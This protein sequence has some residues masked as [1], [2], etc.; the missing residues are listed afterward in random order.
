MR[1][2]LC[3]SLLIAFGLGVM[4]SVGLCQGGF[5]IDT[6][7]INGDEIA[8]VRGEL[9]VK[10]SAPSV[11]H[12][13]ALEMGATV[14]DSLPRIGWWRFRFPEGADVIPSWQSLQHD[15]RLLHC[16]LNTAW[17]MPVE[18]N[19]TE[20]PAEASRDDEIQWP[21]TITRAVDAW[22]QAPPVSNVLIAI[23]DTGCDID[24]PK[25][26]GCSRIQYGFDWKHWPQFVPPED[27][28]GH[29]THRVGEIAA[30][31]NGTLCAGI[32]Q[33]CRVR[34]DKI[35]DDHPTYP[36]WLLWAAAQA[37]EWVVF[38]EGA[39]VVSCSFYGAYSSQE[40]FYP[41]RDMLYAINE[42]ARGTVVMCCAGNDG[43]QYP[44]R[45]PAAWSCDLE[46]LMCVGSSTPDDLLDAISSWRPDQGGQLSFL[47]PG[48]SNT[49]WT[50]EI[51][52]GYV[53][54]PA[55]GATSGATA[56]ASGIAG[57]LISKYPALQRER[58]REQLQNTA[59]M[60]PPPSGFE[61]AD[62]DCWGHPCWCIRVGSG[63]VD[64]LRALNLRYRRPCPSA[65][66][67]GRSPVVRG[68]QF[69]A[70]TEREIAVHDILGRH[71]LSFRI[72]GPA[73]ND[74]RLRG[75]L[76]ANGEGR[77]GIRIVRIL[78]A[79][80]TAAWRIVP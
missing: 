56:F 76:L 40:G 72:E 35:T 61:Y 59:T 7:T 43:D 26:Q 51:G 71:L 68:G 54:S 46:C 45:Y 66:M 3:P 48:K 70:P 16:V 8:F 14:H 31:I 44:I 12:A 11:V 57:I 5:D 34:I 74:A 39:R 2:R 29:G 27:Y 13:L 77:K 25:F 58:I 10:P 63:R 52:G 67:R 75:I 23:L 62:S 9:L 22:A 69:E 21:L 42:D 50:T 32:N 41:F 36:R 80:G 33:N 78:D 17:P 64:A 73:P 65:A 47:S 6:V 18:T 19:G 24:H 15:A 20:E 28:H 38:E 49:Y 37:L 4:P 55:V 30:P 1:T 53:K 60:I 79:S